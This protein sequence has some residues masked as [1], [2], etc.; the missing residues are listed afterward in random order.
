VAHKTD[1]KR[2]HA[3]IDKAA[4]ALTAPPSQDEHEAEQRIGV[5]VYVLWQARDVS[6]PDLA[7][8]VAMAMT[9]RPPVPPHGSSTEVWR[10]QTF[11]LTAGIASLDPAAG[12][13]LLGPNPAAD[14]ADPEFIAN[15][16]DLWLSTLALADPAAA[17]RHLPAELHAEEAANLLAILKKRS[18]VLGRLD[19]MHRIWWEPERHDASDDG[20]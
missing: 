1:S 14:L 5:A 15:Y 12:K 16:Q 10:S 13:A 3:L 11:H 20:D 4:A 6:Y 9:T 17:T 7:S 18:A 19:L 2:S 8:L